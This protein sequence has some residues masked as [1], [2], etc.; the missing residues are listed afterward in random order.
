M[1]FSAT[2]LCDVRAGFIE[3]DILLQCPTVG[4]A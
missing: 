1:I 2:E 3:D 4:E